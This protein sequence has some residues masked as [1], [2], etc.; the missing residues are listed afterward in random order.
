M[1]CDFT[2]LQGGKSS[3]PAIDSQSIAGVPDNDFII[4]ILII[5]VLMI[6]FK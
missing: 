5:I 2:L 4:I 1:A 3:I 6:G